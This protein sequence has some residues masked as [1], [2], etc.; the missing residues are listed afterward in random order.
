MCGISQRA[1]TG[2]ATLGRPD[3]SRDCL[4]QPGAWTSRTECVEKRKLRERAHRPR[5]ADP[6][7]SKYSLGFSTFFLQ[8][9][10]LPF[11]FSG[12]DWATRRF[13]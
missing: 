12:G 6:I 5:Q 13:L 4:A 2:A 10:C 9:S 3:G 11:Q 7:E 8:A 1:R